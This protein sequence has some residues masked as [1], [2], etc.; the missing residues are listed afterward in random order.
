[1]AR[2]HHHYHHYHHGDDQ[3]TYISGWAVVA[4]I[5]VIIWLWKILLV[6]ATVAVLL[7]CVWLFVR[8]WRDGVDAQMR[9]D[10]GLRRRADEQHAALHRADP[11]GLY[12]NFP[13]ADV[14]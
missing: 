1:M 13:P 9:A 7:A 10:E 3:V 11:R 8:W 5:A 6:A 2:V 4:L 14:S 12:G